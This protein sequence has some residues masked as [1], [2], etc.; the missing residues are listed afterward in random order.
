MC[1][2]GVD[3]KEH[4]D[5]RYDGWVYTDQREKIDIEMLEIVIE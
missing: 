2:N 5:E 3:M 4:I 1:E